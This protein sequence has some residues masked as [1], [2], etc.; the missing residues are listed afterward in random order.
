MI[1]V[2]FYH[3]TT[4]ISIESP[5][6]ESIIHQMKQNSKWNVLKL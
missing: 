5:E 4:R 2:W 1:I 6:M 3:P